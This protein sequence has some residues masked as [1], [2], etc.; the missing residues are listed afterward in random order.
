M[1][2]AA[3]LGEIGQPVAGDDGKLDERNFYGTPPLLAYILVLLY[4]RLE[5]NHPSCYSKINM[6][7]KKGYY[8]RK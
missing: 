6:Y 5:K 1:D 8:G 7:K 4:H 3:D 2:M